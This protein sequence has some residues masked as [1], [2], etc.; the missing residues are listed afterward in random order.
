[1]KNTQK[2]LGLERRQAEPGLV[3]QVL[4]VLF[5]ILGSF[6]CVFHVS[7]VALIVLRYSVLSVCFERI[8]I[9]TR[10]RIRQRTGSI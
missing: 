2:N 8:R 1:M 4:P 10:I 3:T 7:L 5:L 6:E 9:R